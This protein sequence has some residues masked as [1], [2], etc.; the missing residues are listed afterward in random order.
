MLLMFPVQ[1]LTKLQY[2]M[3]SI[4][5]IGQKFSHRFINLYYLT[6]DKIFYSITLFKYKSEK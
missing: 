2:S 6:V 1:Y 5:I 3:S 4:I